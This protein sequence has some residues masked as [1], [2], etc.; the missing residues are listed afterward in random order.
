M[1]GIGQHPL[2]SSKF[3]KTS[4]VHTF[5]QPSFL[6]MLETS[7]VH[8]PQRWC[9]KGNLNLMLHCYTHCPIHIHSKRTIPVSRCSCAL[10]RFRVSTRICTYTPM[11]VKNGNKRSNTTETWCPSS[12]CRNYHTYL[13]LF[14]IQQ[15]ATDKWVCVGCSTMFL[16]KSNVCMTMG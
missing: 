2:N 1:P 11:L 7:K 5:S 16:A 9:P 13:N 4:H 10:C 8:Q 14:P 3:S 6:K 15:Q 12:T